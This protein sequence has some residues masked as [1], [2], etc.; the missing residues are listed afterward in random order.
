MALKRINKELT[1]LGRYER[2]PPPS[3]PRNLPSSAKMVSGG[4]ASQAGSFLLGN[5][6]CKRHLYDTSMDVRDDFKEDTVMLTSDS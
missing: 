1:D 5:S 2:K 4:A 6:R 3:F